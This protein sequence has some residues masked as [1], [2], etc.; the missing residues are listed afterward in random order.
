MAILANRT[1]INN[2]PYEFIKICLLAL[3]R[4]LAIGLIVIS[5]KLLYFSSPISISVAS[6]EIVGYFISKGLAVYEEVFEKINFIAQKF[7]Y[8]RDLEAENIALKL[9]I[10]RLNQLQ[11]D[12][13]SIQAENLALKKLLTIVKDNEYDYAT[14]R[15]LSVSINPFR[16]VAI[17]GAGKNHGIKIDQVVRNNEGLVG[18]IIEVSDNY[19]KI[20]LVNDTNSRIPVITA[21]SRER[22]ILTGNNEKITINYLQ[23]NCTIKKGEKVVT[24]GDGKLYPPGIEVA[25]VIKVNGRDVLVKPVTNLYKTDFVTIY[26]NSKPPL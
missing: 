8:L 6:L 20:M 3:K 22:G 23:D 9:E 14:A 2:S 19:S 7:D 25:T 15:L 21:V 26:L 11:S 17:I 10:T 13:Q 12:I 5:V 18:R 4:F 24:S 1:R 16:K